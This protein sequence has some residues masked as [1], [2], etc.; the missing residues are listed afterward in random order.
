MQI[1]SV[2]ELKQAVRALAADSGIAG[3]FL[4]LFGGLDVSVGVGMTEKEN[5]F[6]L[7]LR[8]R[9]GTPRHLT[10]GFRVRK[11]A[12]GEVDIRVTGPVHAIGGCPGGPPKTFPLGIGA[13]IGHHT[14]RGGTVGFFARRRSDGAV[15]VVSN[16]HILAAEDRGR[17]GDPVL[18]PSV[19][20]GGRAE[21]VRAVL[22][23][24]GPQYPRLSGGGLKRSDCAFARL[25]TTDFDP[26][27]LEG[28]GTLQRTIAVPRNRMRV[29]KIGRSTRRT[30]GQVIAFDFD[31]LQVRNYHFGTVSFQDQIEIE[32]LTNRTF[33]DPGDSGSL[34]FDALNRP[35]GLLFAET[36]VGGRNGKG[37]HYATPMQ[38]VLNEL[39]VDII[40]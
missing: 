33:S 12:R 23:D 26:R 2:L 5:D 7:A 36:A 15:G 22:V 28:G 24:S 34:V 29:S 16:N 6:R 25:T 14:I 40:T 39:Q 35:V 13:S 20:D 11:M 27:T 37:L 30:S 10:F 3:E 17:E 32:G 38:T 4:N 1:D 8:L 19:C 9:H 31:K 18:H 21:D